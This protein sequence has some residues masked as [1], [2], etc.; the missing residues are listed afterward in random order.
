LEYIYVFEYTS[1]PHLFPQIYS[2]LP[3]YK[4]KWNIFVS[5]ILPRLYSNIICKNIVKFFQK[6]DM[7]YIQTCTPLE[8]N[9]MWH[10]EGSYYS[11][12]SPYWFPFGLALP[13]QSEIFSA[14]TNKFHKGPQLF[15]TTII[16]VLHT[17]WNSIK[18]RRP[19]R[20]ALDI[21]ESTCNQE[22]FHIA[23]AIMNSQV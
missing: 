7:K 14:S 4:M 15:H 20:G 12:F 22:I 10:L 13:W 3:F 6:F 11:V 5:N 17:K 19:W 8:S 2:N 21:L 1:T 9:I 16:K 18:V 23:R